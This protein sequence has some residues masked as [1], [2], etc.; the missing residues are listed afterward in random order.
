LLEE[1]D[2]KMIPMWE[3][4]IEITEKISVIEDLPSD[5]FEKNNSLLE[6]SKLRLKLSFLI[7]ESIS[8]QIDKRI[9]IDEISH[10]IDSV[11]LTIK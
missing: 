2:E 3:K 5:L 10:K 8:K 1:V 7:K 6:Y 11:L 9:E 4:N